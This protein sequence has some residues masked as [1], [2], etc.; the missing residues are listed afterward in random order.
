MSICSRTYL[1]LSMTTRLTGSWALLLTAYGDGKRREASIHSLSPAQKQAYQSVLGGVAVLLKFRSAER[2]AMLYYCPSPLLIWHERPTAGQRALTSPSIWRRIVSPR[3][4]LICATAG[5]SK[6]KA[7]SHPRQVRRFTSARDKA[8]GF[9][10]FIVTRRLIPD[11][12]IYVWKLSA[13]G[14]LLRRSVL[15][16]YHQT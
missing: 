9:V 5:D 1:W 4:F 16:S 3:N 10:G 13:R 15:T 6:P 11:Q 7:L 14:T 2:L 8:K 12:N